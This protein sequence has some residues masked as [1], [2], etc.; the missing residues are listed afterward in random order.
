MS[1]SRRK[2]TMDHLV[3]ARAGP[4]IGGER[5]SK[6]K[7]ASMVA[8]LSRVAVAAFVWLGAATG[9]FAQQPLRIVMVVHA[10]ASDPFWATI[11]EG[12]DAAA[13]AVD[14]E[15]SYRAP[16][17]FDTAAMAELVEAAVAERPDGL[18]VS[19]P[20]AAVLAAPIDAAVA[21]GIPVV[22]IN[23]GFDVGQSL[24][25]LLHVGQGEYEAGRVAGERM[26]EL[27]ASKALCL[28][29]EVGNVALDLRCKGFIDGFGGSVE[30]LAIEAGAARETIAATLA[31]D[32]AIDAVLALSAASAGE[33]AIAAAKALAPDRAIAVGTFDISESVLAEVAAG[34]AA[35][36]I[37]QQPFLQGY[38]PVQFLALHNRRG[39][40][41]VSNVSTGPKLVDAAEARRRLG[42]RTGEP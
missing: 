14:V 30:V 27:G 33:P 31:E 12:A 28:N 20:D 3:T 8:G 7:E 37:D 38:L 21:A 36:A 15:L 11:K 26:R 2:T 39:V 32:A 16:A 24:G 19:I 29:H 6:A 17:T 34:A 35:F 40:A 9:A 22:S 18:I 25:A 42:L 5:A 10:P 41:P 13:A 1:Q 4:R 23:S